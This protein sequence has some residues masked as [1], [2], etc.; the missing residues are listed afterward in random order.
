MVQ[1]HEERVDD[2]AQR[3]EEVDEGVHDEE[4]DEVR[5]P[6][7]A[8]R[9]LPTK[10]QQLTLGLDVF[11]LRHAVVHAEKTCAHTAVPP[12]GGGVR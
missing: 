7:P 12:V 2:D 5:D 4:F 8:R 6:V 11:L 3:N 9:A 1:C 10:Q